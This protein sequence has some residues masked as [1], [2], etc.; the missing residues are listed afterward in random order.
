MRSWL[1]ILLACVLALGSASP[2]LGQQ[3]G[4]VDQ[5]TADELTAEVVQR[6]QI[7]HLAP[8]QLETDDLLQRVR[9]LE[10]RFNGPGGSVAT[11]TRGSTTGLWLNNKAVVGNS[12]QDGNPQVAI[13]CQKMP[14]VGDVAV[15]GAYGTSSK[16][17]GVTAALV[18]GQQGSIQL[19]AS[20]GKP[21]HI[22]ADQL[23]EV[24]RLLEKPDEHA[25]RTKAAEVPSPFSS[26]PRR[27]VYNPDQRYDLSD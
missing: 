18:A 26:A 2:L 10:A 13:Y 21:V 20:D 12:N 7:K 23:R 22:S 15:V 19:I 11:A 17:H 25:R 6:L 24:L 3:P 4:P 5:V 16:S 8:L 1:L 27:F 14:G 9:A